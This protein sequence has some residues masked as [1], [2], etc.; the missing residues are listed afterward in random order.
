MGMPTLFW[1]GRE[2]DFNLLVKNNL[3]ENL[4]DL[5]IF[6]K[7]KF[8][9]K[10]TLMLADQILSNLEYIH[11]KGFGSFGNLNA[12]TTQSKNCQIFEA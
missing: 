2:G 1:Y 10:T 11:F 6:C 3:G 12:D 8:S 9:L 5:H 4:Q 7:L